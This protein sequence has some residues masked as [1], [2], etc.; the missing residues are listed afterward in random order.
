M[1]FDTRVA[2]R[3][4]AVQIRAASFYIKGISLSAVQGNNWTAIRTIGINNSVW[5]KCSINGWQCSV[6]EYKTMQE[7]Q[8]S[9]DNFML[10]QFQC[11]QM[12]QIFLKPTVQH[13]IVNCRGFI[14]CHFH[15][16][17]QK[18]KIKSC[19]MVDSF[20]QSL[21][22]V[23]LNH[24]LLSVLLTKSLTFSSISNNLWVLVASSSFLRVKKFLKKSNCEVSPWFGDRVPWHNRNGRSK[25][26]Y[27]RKI[28]WHP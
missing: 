17:K 2:H 22:S 21:S 24:V 12:S 8:F 23:F 5:C 25:T 28:N 11:W 16:K 6:G 1:R 9:S 27:R 14:S 20:S 4:N 3:N 7:R 15:D 13:R 19:L 10:M 26:E 18:T